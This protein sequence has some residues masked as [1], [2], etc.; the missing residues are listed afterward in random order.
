MRARIGVAVPLPRV[1]LVHLQLAL[2]LLDGRGLVDRVGRLVPVVIR[3]EVALAQRA[4]RA[5]H[6]LISFFFS[7]ISQLGRIAKRRLRSAPS[8]TRPSGA[9]WFSRARHAGDH[10]H[11]GLAVEEHLLDEVLEAVGLDVVLEVEAHVAGGLAVA[12][13]QRDAVG[14]VRLHVDDEVLALRTLL[15]DRGELVGLRFVD[16]E[17][18]AVHA[19]RGGEA[20]GQAHRAGHERAAVDVELRA[21][22]SPISRISLRPASGAAFCGRGRNS[23]FE[24]LASASASRRPS[25]GRARSC[26][27]TWLKP[28]MNEFSAWRQYS[29]IS[30]A[31]LRGSF[32]F[33]CIRVDSAL[34]NQLVDLHSLQ[35][36]ILK[37][38]G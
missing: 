35:G 3:R 6:S 28:P 8:S 17:H 33:I 16:V 21:R 13:V 9:R 31:R 4:L 1:D 37:E 26:E 10:H 18:L 19:V 7:P 5:G 12:E 27:S 14:E 25:S 29:R 23:S 34:L 38:S 2:H 22:A 11:L 32:A 20:G 15:V 30:F 36:D 24:T